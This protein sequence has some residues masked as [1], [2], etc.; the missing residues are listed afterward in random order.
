MRAEVHWNTAGLEIHSDKGV[1][2]KK[3]VHC[4]SAITSFKNKTVRFGY[5]L[6]GYEA[7]ATAWEAIPGDQPEC[8]IL[9]PVYNRRTRRIIQRSGV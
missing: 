2:L 8:K 3:T 6:G 9:L 1:C 4:E 7:S 5:L